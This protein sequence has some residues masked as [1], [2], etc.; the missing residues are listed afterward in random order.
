MAGV[1]RFSH[2]YFDS[3][4]DLTFRLFFNSLFISVFSLAAR[5]GRFRYSPISPGPFRRRH[6]KCRRAPVDYKRHYFPAGII[7]LDELKQ[8]IVAMD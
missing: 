2:L 1:A 3:E 8:R 6:V 4:A 7:M 5:L